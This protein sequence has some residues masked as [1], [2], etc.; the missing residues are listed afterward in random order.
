MP[1]I[2]WARLRTVDNVTS[3]PR[4]GARRQ[5]SRHQH[6][7]V[8]A[9]LGADTELAKCVVAPAPQRLIGLDRAAV[10]AADAGML[11]RRFVA[12]ARRCVAELRRPVAELT[13]RIIAPTPERLIQPD[14]ACVLRS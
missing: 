5:I 4:T 7:I 12:D 2:S 11:P 1:M 14:R 6:R 8:G 13:P 3:V 9:E 10:T